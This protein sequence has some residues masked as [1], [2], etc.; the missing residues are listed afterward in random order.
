MSHFTLAHRLGQ[1]LGLPAAARRLRRFAA[2]TDASMTI[3]AMLIL[4]VYLQFYI[5]A[6]A[7]F[8][9]FRTA[10]INEK[11]A[12]TI[13]DVITRR[14]P[15]APVDNAFVYWTNDLYDYLLEGR[16]TDT[17]VRITSIT[18]SDLDQKYEV[19]WSKGTHGQPRLNNGDIPALTPRL[20]VMPGGDTIILVETHSKFGI[21]LVGTRPLLFT[22][23]G[24]QN[25]QTFIFTRPRFA[26]R[27][28]MDGVP[29][30]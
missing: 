6:Y 22:A 8:D 25:L 20:P 24:N 13:A 5:A 29:C 19:E 4:P 11:A 14:N 7:V 23:L 2:D 21:G 12:Y 30:G 17:W 18:Y 28:C 10:V 15:G 9:G 3:E 16:G 1:S 27:I 26:P